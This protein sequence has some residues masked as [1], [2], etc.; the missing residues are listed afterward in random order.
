[1]AFLGL[2][3]LLQ[4]Q[5]NRT[6]VWRIVDMLLT[7]FSTDSPFCV[8][9]VVWGLLMNIKGWWDK[10]KRLLISPAHLVCDDIKGWTKHIFL[11]NLFL[12]PFN[13]VTRELKIVLKNTLFSRDTMNWKKL[14]EERRVL[15][16]TGKK[17]QKV[18]QKWRKS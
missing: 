10:I 3:I 18:W 11:L 16:T 6:L 4:T 15:P 9:W 8:T 14:K 1:M 2:Y 5:N 12:F 7:D 17:I 13:C